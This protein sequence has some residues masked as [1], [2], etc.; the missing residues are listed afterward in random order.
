MKL[1]PRVKLSILC[2][3][4]TLAILF[5]N[6]RSLLV[7]FVSCLIILML[8]KCNIKR[9]LKPFKSLIKLVIIMSLIQSVF[10]Q[11]NHVIISFFNINVITVE[12]L[13]RGLE[14]FLRMLTILFSASI[15][16]TCS[17]REIIQGL[18][19]LK[20]PYDLSLMA[21]MGIKFLPILQQQFSDTFIAI[22]LRGVDIKK[23]TLKEKVKLISYLLM[24]VVA[25]AIETAKKVSISIQLRGF[26]AYPTRTSYYSLTLNKI[27][28]IILMCNLLY[29][30]LFILCFGG[31][32]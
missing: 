9:L 7:L 16:K 17:S 22:Q 18:T 28:Y 15:L 19:Q 6:V 26:R 10:S 12:G 30:A 32:N 23:Q 5:Q 27:D 20:V 14:F 2:T 25:G 11:G 21:V 29:V 3:L 13:I 24:P 1:D 31:I 8:L 4:S